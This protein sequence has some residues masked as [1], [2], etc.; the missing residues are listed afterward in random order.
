M[1]N[2]I[3]VL[4]AAA[5][6]CL[7]LTSNASAIMMTGGSFDNGTL[8]FNFENVLGT[9]TSLMSLTYQVGDVLDEPLYYGILTVKD[10]RVEIDEWDVDDYWNVTREQERDLGNFSISYFLLE[11][12]NPV[13]PA[14]NLY[15]LA[16]ATVSL[17]SP[18]DTGLINASFYGFA[19]D[20]VTAD[21]AW[22]DITHA[23][24]PVP[25]PATFML[26]GTGLLGI[27]GATRKKRSSKA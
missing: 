19:R 8:D 21:C 6:M 3:V 10:F 1:R 27:A 25:E 7:L 9:D 16:S 11:A 18:F 20:G 15:D 5:F 14:N 13:L 23:A 12:V 22:T 24:A 4:L 2:K 26:L 17:T